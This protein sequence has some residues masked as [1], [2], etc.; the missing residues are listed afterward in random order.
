MQSAEPQEAGTHQDDEEYRDGGRG[1]RR[2]FSQAFDE[3]RHALAHALPHRTA[4]LH[5]EPELVL[6]GGT[7]TSG[8]E[9]IVELPLQCLE[10]QVVVVAHEP[11]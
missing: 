6:E 5:A 2:R 7:R 1:H 3:A 8:L 11:P 9:R 4:C 10:L